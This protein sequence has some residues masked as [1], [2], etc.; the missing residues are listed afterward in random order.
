MKQS[1]VAPGRLASAHSVR[2]GRRNSAGIAEKTSVGIS[3]GGVSRYIIF[4]VHPCW[5]GRTID[6]D[7]GNVDWTLPPPRHCEE[8]SDEAVQPLLV[9]QG[10]IASL[11]S[12]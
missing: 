5:N 2:T 7:V 8:R 1:V 6:D 9:R 3:F 11:R 10:W 12:Q 4:L